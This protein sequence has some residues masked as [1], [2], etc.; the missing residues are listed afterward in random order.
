VASGG[1]ASGS[2][3]LSSAVGRSSAASATAASRRAAI[4]RTSS[5]TADARPRPRRCPLG[6][7]AAAC[8]PQRAARRCPPRPAGYAPGVREG[9]GQPVLGL[10][11]RARDDLVRLAPRARDDLIRLRPCAIDR[12][13]SLPLRRGR[14][15]LRLRLGPRGRVLGLFTRGLRDHLGG[16]SRAVQDAACLLTNAVEGVAD[17]GRRRAADLELG[18]H[19][20]DALDVRVD[21]AAIV[22]ADGGG[23]RGV[24]QLLPAT[25]RGRRP[26]GPCRRRRVTLVVRRLVLA[27]R[28]VLAPRGHVLQLVPVAARTLRASVIPVVTPRWRSLTR[29]GH[30]Q[31]SYLPISSAVASTWPVIA[32]LLRT[33]RALSPPCPSP[34]PS[35]AHA[36]SRCPSARARQR[37][38]LQSWRQARRA[39]ARAPER[40]GRGGIR[41][42]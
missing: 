18:D 34:S 2:R 32:P 30:A 4:P 39:D 1:S 41:A 9:P 38:A 16:L 17:C 37:H 19:A 40:C 25:D 6:A 10:G 26:P 31:R 22:A 15:L 11:V 8:R 28:P 23:E 7:T 13:T 24:A 5:S 12:L 33:S 29:A 20:V 42:R 36:S 21:R 14:D 3:P 35:T 27:H